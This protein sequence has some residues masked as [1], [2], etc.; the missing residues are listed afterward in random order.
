MEFHSQSKYLAFIKEAEP[1]AQYLHGDQGEE[2]LADCEAALGDTI[3][4]GDLFFTKDGRVFVNRGY[5]DQ[6]GQGV[7]KITYLDVSLFRPEPNDL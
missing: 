7:Y 2:L 5:E 1:L 3:E 4:K 6:E